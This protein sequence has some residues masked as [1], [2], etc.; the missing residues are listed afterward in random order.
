RASRE[1]AQRE[2]CGTKPPLSLRRL[3]NAGDFHVHGGGRR[4]KG[5][6]AGG[7][8]PLQLV[9]RA[10]QPP[11]NPSLISRELREW[12]AVARHR[13]EGAAKPNLLAPPAAPSAL[14]CLG[15]NPEHAPQAPRARSH[16]ICQKALKLSRGAE[17][18]P[19]LLLE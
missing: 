14:E 2:N 17:R 9:E 19:Q 16:A 13:T 10:G 6:R 18:A 7:L 4:N 1:C 15:F 12:V 8:E 5:A 11:L 3:L